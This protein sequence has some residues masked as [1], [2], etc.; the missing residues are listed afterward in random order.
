MDAEH[1]AIAHPTPSAESMRSPVRTP[2]GRIQMQQTADP[3]CDRPLPASGQDH[4]LLEQIIA[5][6]DLL[7]GVPVLANVDFGYTSPLATLPISGRPPS[8]PAAPAPCT[9]A[10]REMPVPQRCQR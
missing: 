7:D 8:S 10:A 3:P 2:E 6:Q 9:S 4:P 1:L 5:L